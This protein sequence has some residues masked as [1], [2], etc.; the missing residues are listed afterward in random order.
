MRRLV[1]SPAALDDQTLIDHRPQLGD[2]GVVPALEVV[3][4]VLEAERAGACS[5]SG[6]RQQ[7]EPGAVIGGQEAVVM[8]AQQAVHDD[9]V[10]VGEV[11][12]AARD[13]D[14]PLVA[15]PRSVPCPR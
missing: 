12:P 7:L 5:G 2:A 13:V 10:L 8:D 6:V 1:P 11:D 3:P 9:A 15:G 4:V 14:D